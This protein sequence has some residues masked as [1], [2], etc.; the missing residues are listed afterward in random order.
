M[1]TDM[2]LVVVGAALLADEPALCSMWG[3][4]NTAERAIRDAERV[5]ESRVSAV[6]GQMPF[7][8]LDIDDEP[9][10]QS[11][12]GYIERNAIALLSNA[13]KTPL[14]TP[15]KEWLGYRCPRDRVRA[16]GLWN[17]N[18]VDGDYDPALFDTLDT[19]IG[20]VE[21]SA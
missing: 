5:L 20:A 3:Q 15:S 17:Q 12:R 10:P 11:L 18:H 4:G 9:G 16:S 8:Y 7:V 13:G 6:I 1:M 21:R 2:G 19:L 14:D